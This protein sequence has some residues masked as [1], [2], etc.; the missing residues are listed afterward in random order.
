MI[1]VHPRISPLYSISL[2]ETT[3]RNYGMYQTYIF[4][5]L[6]IFR[7]LWESSLSSIGATSPSLPMIS[8]SKSFSSWDNH[9]AWCGQLGIMGYTKIATAAV[10]QPSTYRLHEMGFIIR[11]ELIIEI[12]LGWKFGSIKYTSIRC[13]NIHRCLI[14]EIKKFHNLQWRSTSTHDIHFHFWCQR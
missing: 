3:P 13:E 5:S 10:M 7:S 1:V 4:Q 11:G 12:Q 9:F 6:R 8:P 14:I 2:D